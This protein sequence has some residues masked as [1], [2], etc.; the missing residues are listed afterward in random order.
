MESRLF[1]SYIQEADTLLLRLD[2]ASA[3]LCIAIEDE[4]LAKRAL[5]DAESSL[6]ATE[7]EIVMEAE[8][9]SITDKTGLLAGIAK[10]SKAYGYA[11]EYLL[12]KDRGNGSAIGYISAEVRRLQGA[13]DSALIDRQQAETRFSA[14]RH[15]ADLMAAILKGASA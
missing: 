7:A 13:A 3:N 15:A 9:A 6:S 11:L 4:T 10:T 1:D 2:E 12:S 14:I 5:K 8:L